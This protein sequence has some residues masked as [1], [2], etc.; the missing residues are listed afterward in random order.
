MLADGTVDLVISHAPETE[1]RYLAEHRD[2][3]YRKI[4]FNHF[5]VV[6]PRDDPAHVREARDIAEAFKRIAASGAPFVSRGDQSGTHEREQ[7]LWKAAGICSVGPGR[8]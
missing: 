6:G 5:L 1:T 2:W 3:Q 8:Y 4:A 7:S